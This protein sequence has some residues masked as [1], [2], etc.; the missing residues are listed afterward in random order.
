[1]V[2]LTVE[3]AAWLQLFM[4]KHNGY[5]GNN[6]VDGL[7]GKLESIPEVRKERDRQAPRFERVLADYVSSK[8]RGNY[9][10]F[11]VNGIR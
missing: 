2:E 7:Y 1:M 4:G 11:D 3:A 5:E 10:C 9:A 8:T 6:P